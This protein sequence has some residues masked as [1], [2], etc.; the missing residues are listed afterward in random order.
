M[1][2][3]YEV[4]LTEEPRCF[5]VHIG[6]RILR[7]T[8]NLRAMLRQLRE[9]QHVQKHPP[10]ELAA[11]LLELRN[12]PL[13]CR[14]LI[15]ID[16]LCIDQDDLKERAAQ[17]ALMS[18]IYK[19]A[20]NCT[21]W[22]GQIDQHTNTAM[23]LLDDFSV[24]LRDRLSQDGF[25]KS[26]PEFMRWIFN[27]PSESI[28]ALLALFRRTW[29]S[30]V[31]VRQEIFLSQEVG[32]LCGTVLFRFL[33][34]IELGS[35]IN[36]THL[37]TSLISIARNGGIP[38]APTFTSP[39]PGLVEDVSRNILNMG[40]L[41]N[42][43]SYNR[44]PSFRDAMVMAMG[45][46]STDP[47][48]KI[49]GVLSLISEFQSEAGT[50]VID[51]DYTLPVERVY[52]KAT[53]AIATC[54]EKS[55]DFL[56]FCHPR[57][58]KTLKSLPSWCPDYACSN[59]IVHGSDAIAHLVESLWPSRPRINVVRDSLLEVDGFR[60]DV[61]TQTY[62]NLTTPDAIQILKLV[63]GLKLEDSGSPKRNRPGRV[64]LL[65]RLLLKDKFSSQAPAHPV[66]G[67]FLPQ[68]IATLITT[69]GVPRDEADQPVSAMERKLEIQEAL[70]QLYIITAELI[71][72][73]ADA[74][75]F[76]F[77]LEALQA[78][79][80][81]FK[82]TEPVSYDDI[83]QNA[84]SKLLESSLSSMR[85]QAVYAGLS[86]ELDAVI[87]AGAYVASPDSKFPFDPKMFL[88]TWASNVLPVLVG[89][90]ADSL[91]F[92][93]QRSTTLGMG[94]KTT[95]PGD[96]IWIIHGVTDPVIL[97]HLENGNYEFCGKVHV[98][99]IVYDDTAEEREHW[100]TMTQKV[101]IQ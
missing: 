72:L 21:V 20:K 76:L 8:R 68:M 3:I 42:A 26:R 60:Y 12:N 80:E 16:A 84:Y 69:P 37:S 55:L 33:P 86:S 45:C 17:V 91:I 51:A 90:R 35:I 7:A 83:S 13:R 62:T 41:V 89:Y 97:R 87:G 81:E 67:L 22:L 82:A 30:R 36:S 74:S 48:D 6:G 73:E 19:R 28:A 44:L 61:I 57:Q 52:V 96:E 23:D 2:P 54:A 29:F 101:T 79:I 27:L 78:I 39:E 24:H 100:L 59:P 46:A 53:A 43:I 88:G 38:T 66:A 98:Q 49:Y 85:R 14:E 93:S 70:E 5:P 56:E 58:L 4:R 31:W 47:R 25:T 63:A 94:C 40:T 75:P 1:Y 65:W 64:E 9:I 15:W 77:D 32:G 92:A 50:P 34:L 18:L 10:A 11:K 99:G 71:D 95:M